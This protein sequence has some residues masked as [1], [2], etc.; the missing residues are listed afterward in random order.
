MHHFTAFCIT[1]PPI[2]SYSRKLQDWYTALLELF[3]SSLNWLHLS[4]LRLLSYSFTKNK[5]EKPK[6]KS[7]C[8]F[9][10]WVHCII[11]KFVS[12]YDI[13]YLEKTSINRWN[14]LFLLYLMPGFKLL[15]KTTKL[16]SC[17]SFMIQSVLQGSCKY[18]SYLKNA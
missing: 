9:K 17:S 16:L 11:T 13:A 4:K 14:K 5:I 7:L 1:P 3:S 12:Y 15:V 8:I 6:I 10:I 18:I 2:I